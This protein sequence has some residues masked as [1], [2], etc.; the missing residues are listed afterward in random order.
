MIPYA[1]LD[2][3]KGES[4]GASSSSSSDRINNLQNKQYKLEGA[5]DDKMLAAAAQTMKQT[6]D[7]DSIIID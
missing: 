7:L 6:L 5:E 3:K 4:G 2:I 1:E